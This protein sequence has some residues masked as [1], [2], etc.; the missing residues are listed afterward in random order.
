[1]SRPRVLV[2]LPLIAVA[3]ACQEPDVGSRCDIAWGPDTPAPT[4]ATI[5]GDYLETGNVACEDLVCIVSPAGPSSGKYGS[6]AGGDESGTGGNCGYCSKPCVSDADCYKDETG[7]ECRQM[8]LDPEFIA[9][10]SEE[11]R[12]KYLG[13]VGFS[14][15]CAVPR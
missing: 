11:V 1:M 13:D 7:L 5:G 9:S 8:V 14:S 2:L 3:I 12:Q 15:Y 6:C 4:P 10:L